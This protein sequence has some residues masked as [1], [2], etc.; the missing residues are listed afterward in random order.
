MGGKGGAQ[1]RKDGQ[2]I[3]DLCGLGAPLRDGARADP[4]ISARQIAGQDQLGLGLQRL[5]GRFKHGL[6]A[7]R[8]FYPKLGF[9]FLR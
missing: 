3:G 8:S 1:Q 2:T 4:L 6:S 9:L 7:V 5:R